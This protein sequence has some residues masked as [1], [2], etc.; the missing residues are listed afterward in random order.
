MSKKVVIGMSGG[1]D[2][3][4]AAYLLKEKG[5]EVIGATIQTWFDTDSK[6]EE[7]VESTVEDAKK[8]CKKLGIPFYVIDLRNEFK[9]N[10]I[11]YF[12][13]E[14]MCGKTPNP[15]VQCN[16]TIKFGAFLEKAKELG[17][18]YLATGHYAKIVKEDNGR[19]YIKKAEDDNKDQTY[20]LYKLSQE[21]LRH[22]LMPCGEYKKSEIREIAKKIGLEVHD[23]KDSEEVCFIPDNNY[24]E[25]IKKIKN[26]KIK[27]GYFVDKNG[28]I[29]GKHKGIMNYTI[30]QRKGL[31]IALGKPVFVTKIIASKNRIVLGDEE[32]IFKNVLIA[33]DTNFII[34][35]NLNYELR[36]KAK[37]RY[38]MKPAEASIIPI[39]KNKVKVVF[40]DK[41]R[42]ITKGQSVVFYIEDYLVGGGI[43][44]KVL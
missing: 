17:A 29:L 34:F 7:A 10:V 41:Q 14:Y 26:G 44:D 38:S 32:E 37:I 39:D 13:N 16:K 8:V 23:K 18:D 4:V 28:N 35:D 9:K 30:G 40:K 6:N 33:K 2:S 27:E 19:Y 42:A 31:G 11:D 3:S 24:G 43:I 36:V 5:Y 20:M 21:Q 25:Y 22:I 15:C 1:V 12:V